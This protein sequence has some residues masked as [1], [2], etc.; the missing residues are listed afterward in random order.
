M[1]RFGETNRNRAMQ[2]LDADEKG[3]TQTYTLGGEQRVAVVNE[4]GLYSPLFVMRSI[5]KGRMY[6]G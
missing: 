5:E 4:A 6:Y 2:V 3:Y 1:R